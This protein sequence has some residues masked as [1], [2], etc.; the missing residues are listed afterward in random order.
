[1]HI[2]YTAPKVLTRAVRPSGCPQKR[3]PLVPPERGR[4]GDPAAPPLRAPAQNP[5]H[6][7]VNKAAVVADIGAV[8]DDCTALPYGPSH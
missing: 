6:R 1:M 5:T 4:E 8:G 2:L 3:D 7:P